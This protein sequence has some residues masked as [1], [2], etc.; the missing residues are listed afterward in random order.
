MGHTQCRILAHGFGVAPEEAEDGR[1]KRLNDACD[2][3]GDP[4]MYI[5][6]LR[7]LANSN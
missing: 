5:E 7:Q 3:G 1:L 6:P 2:V 4:P